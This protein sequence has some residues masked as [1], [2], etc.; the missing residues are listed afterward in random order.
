MNNLKYTTCLC[1]LFKMGEGGKLRKPISEF[2]VKQQIWLSYLSVWKSKNWTAEQWKEKS[3][4]FEPYLEVGHTKGQE[5]FFEK[6][7]IK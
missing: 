6:N 2:Q 7:K 3:W 1:F 5:P 4:C